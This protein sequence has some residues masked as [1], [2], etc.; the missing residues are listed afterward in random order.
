MHP[1]GTR[2]IRI[3]D[4]KNATKAARNI[5]VQYGKLIENRLSLVAVVDRYNNGKITR[6]AA[7]AE[8]QSKI[9]YSK[10]GAEKRVPLT[11]IPGK[12]GL[13]KPD[14]RTGWL[15]WQDSL[16][17]FLYFEESMV[18]PDP[19]KY[20]AEWKERPGSGSRIG[21][22]NLWIYEKAT[23]EKHFSITTEAGAKV[24]PYFKVPEPNDPNLYYFIVQGEPYG[25]G[26]IRVWLTD[27]T[28]NLLRQLVG[29]LDPAAIEKAVRAAKFEQLERKAAGH[30]FGDLA[31]QVLVP[32]STYDRL[33]EQF[34][35][36]SDE[37]NFKQ[38]IEV[39][40]A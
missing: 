21:S 20:E 23:G 10:S 15:L 13:Q 5:L 2:A 12:N 17:E 18:V 39:L 38:L 25:N 7:I 4:E 6:D 14:L 27:V 3:P 31:V 8:L 11:P 9:G 29:S 28:A 32:I 37:H 34:H 22:R 36:V 19:E 33:I 24:Q 1:A 26:L 35:G 16:R 30:S 40:R